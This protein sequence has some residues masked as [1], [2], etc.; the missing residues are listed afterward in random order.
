MQRW[1]MQASFHVWGSWSRRSLFVWSKTIFIKL[2]PVEPK[3]IYIFILFLL[4]ET[5]LIKFKWF[6]CKT[7]RFT[8]VS[9]F[10]VLIKHSKLKLR[11]YIYTG[12][13]V[14]RITYL[15][16]YEE[17]ARHAIIT[18]LSLLYTETSL[19]LFS[20][21]CLHLHHWLWFVFSFI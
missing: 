3:P 2:A 7:Y 1:E 12:L 9:D 10:Y 6:T 16:I 11:S 18:R 8:D 17:P 5:R 15:N 19:F 21:T 20:I 14:R 4:L 13:S